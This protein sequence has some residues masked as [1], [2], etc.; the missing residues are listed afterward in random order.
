MLHLLVDRR[1][2]RGVEAGTLAGDIFDFAQL[3]L[4]RDAELV[5]AVPRLAEAFRLIRDEFHCHGWA[6]FGFCFR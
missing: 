3:R 6:P 2:Q 4:D 5:T 1:L